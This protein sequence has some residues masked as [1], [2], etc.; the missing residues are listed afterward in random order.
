M[1]IWLNQA[2]ADIAMMANGTMYTFLTHA[3]EAFWAINAQGVVI[4]CNTV[5]CYKIANLKDVESRS[6]CKLDGCRPSGLGW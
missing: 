1:L 3:T 6:A 4:F 2:D 5:A